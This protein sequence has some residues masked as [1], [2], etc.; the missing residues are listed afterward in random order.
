MKKLSD[1]FHFSFFSILS[2]L[3]KYKGDIVSDVPLLVIFKSAA[4]SVVGSRS[5]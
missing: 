4:Q 2:S 3:A 5:A 1:T